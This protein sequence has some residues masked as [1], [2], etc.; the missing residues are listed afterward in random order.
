MGYVSVRQAIDGGNALRL[1]V[2]DADCNESDVTYASWQAVNR[3]RATLFGFGVRESRETVLDLSSQDRFWQH[4][5]DE[6]FQ[7]MIHR[8][9]ALV[10]RLARSDDVG[11]IS[12]QTPLAVPE[13][14]ITG[15]MRLLSARSVMEAYAMAIELV[16]AYFRG[17]AIGDVHYSRPINRN[18]GPLYTTALEYALESLEWPEPVTL[19]QYLDGRAPPEC[20]HVIPVL[21][22][23][24]MQV[25]VLQQADGW[26]RLE[27][28]LRSLSVAHAF[29]L[30]VSGIQ[31][32]RLEAPPP[33]IR[34]RTDRN[35]L[36]LAWL[37]RCR[38]YV[39][40]DVSRSLY[41]T[42][43]AGFIGDG[44]FRKQTARS[45]TITGMIWAARANLIEDPSEYILDA[46]LFAERYPCQPRFLRTSDK[47][48]STLFPEAAQT[49]GDAKYIVEHAVPVLEAA[50]FGQQ[51]ESTWAKL[52]E[53][54]DASRLD[55]VRQTLTAVGLQFDDA[56]LYESP[57]TLLRAD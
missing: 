15:Q 46:G 14:I 32:G 34:T 3:L 50:V 25:P 9:Y 16:S 33:G 45:Q 56:E 11:D 4:H 48:V 24:A 35:E 6:R 17:F 39:G 54:A 26:V 12:S 18:P 30:I 27:G 47:R 21:A 31:E 51:W 52:P 38:A 37:E 43:L 23:A 13:V 53:V 10:R 29:Q 44:E 7:P 28:D 19:S 49:S 2:Y 42:A 57:P 20:Y 8:Y 40:D 36:L 1:P 22:F 5:F 55:T 41:D